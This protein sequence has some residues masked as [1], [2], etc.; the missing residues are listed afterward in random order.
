[1]YRNKKDVDKYV[2]NLISKL[3][4]K[5]F[6]TRAYSIARLYYEVGDY[7]SCKLYVEQYLTQKDN[8]AAAYKLLGQALQKLGQKEKALEQYKIALDIDPTQTSTILDICELLADDDVTIDPGRAKYWC[9]KAEATFPRHPVTFKMRERLI[10]ESNSDPEALVNLLTAELVARPKDALLHTR[11]LKHY[12][13]TNEIKKAVD[14]SCNIEFGAKTFIN[15]YTW[16]ETLVDLLKHDSHNQNDWVF[17]LLLLTVRE[18]ICVLSLTETPSGSSKSLVE[19]NELLHAYDQA[20]EIVTKAGA[21]PGYA[22]FHTGLLQHHRGQFAFIAATF[23]LKKAK[24]DQLSWRDATKF[25]APLMLIAWHTTP[26]DLKVNWLTHATEK[27]QQAARRWYTEGAYRCS[28]S[29]HYLLSNIQDQSQLLLD[30]ISQCCS[31]THWRDKLYEKIFTSRGHLTKIKSSHITSNWFNAPVLRL[32][33]K[34]EVETYD[35][36]AQKEYPN[37]LHHFVWILLNYKNYAHFK[38]TLFDMLTPTTSDCGPETLN[39]LDIH[40]F[41]YCAALTTRQ[42]KHTER[43]YV[44]ADKPTVLPA[45]IT[46]LLCPLSQMKW[47]DCAYKFSQNELGTEL[48]DIRATLSRGI[49]VVRCVDSYGLDPELLCTLGRIFSEKAK[50]TTVVNDK[51]NL[52]IRAGLYY[53]SAIPLLE[54]LKSKIVVKMPEKRLFDY[55]H[56]EL[57]TKDLISLIEES[58][59]FVAVN[60]LNDCDY[61]KVIEILSNLKSPQ[62]YYYLGLTYKKIA[63]DENNT[64]KD[65]NSLET[66]TKCVSLLTRARNYSYK[67]LDS[68]KNSGIN[69]DYP[70]YSDTQ[71]MIE[72]IETHLNKID[73][74]LSDTAVN[75]VGGKYSSDE[76]VSFIGSEYNSA[77]P[78]SHIFRNISSTPKQPNPNVTNYRTATDSHILESTRADQQFLER[79]ENEIKNLQKRDN[80]ISDFMEQS[81]T[82]FEENRKLSNQIISTIHTNIQNTTDQ[83]KLLKIS[84]DNVKDQ[85]DEC[86]NECKDVGDLKKQIAELKKEVNK[87][88]KASSEQTIDESDLYNLEDDYRT[89]ESTSFAA[90]LPFTPPQVLSSFNQR[91]VPPFPVP[92]NPYQ[93]Y[94][95]NLYNFYSQYPQFAQATQVPGAPPLFDP[96]RAPM[97]YPG[98]YTTPDQMYLDVSHLVPPNIPPP[99]VSSVSSVPTVPILPTIPTASTVP[100]A[101]VSVSTTAVSVITSKMVQPPESKEIPRSLPVNVVITSSD[102]LPTCTTTPAPILSVTIPSKHIKGTAHNYQIPMPSTNETK[103]MTPPIFS[104]PSGNKTMNTT[105]PFNNWNQSTVF[106]SQSSNAENTSTDTAS[107]STKGNDTLDNTVNVVDGVFTG[108]SPNT[109]L[110][111]SRTLSE[112]SNTSVENY[113]PCP[114]F[115]PIIPLPAEVKVTTGEEDEITIFSSRAKLFRFIDKQ[116]KE[117]GLGDMKLLKH[118]TTAK[119]RV[120]MRREQIHKICAN[121]I[122]TPEMEIKPM[123]NETKAY[124]WVAN[125]FADE[126][127]VL[128]K[129]CIRFKTADIAQQFYE[130]FEKARQ[131]SLLTV[132]N[133]SKHENK[134]KAESSKPLFTQFTTTVKNTPEQSQTS[135]TVI[136]GFTFSSTPTFKPV[137]TDIKS[138]TKSSELATSKTNVFSGLTFKTTTNSP[139][140]SLFSTSSNQVT[141]NVTKTESNKETIDK[142]NNSDTVEEFEPTVEFKPVVP[143]PAL[144]EQKTGEE[145]E[146]IMFEHRAKLLRFDTSIKE[147]KERGLGNIKLLVH[148][149]NIQ[150]VRL[151]MRREQ[152][153][154]VCCN[155]A[156]TKEMIFQKMP[157]MD[158][159]VTWGATDFS[160][161]ELVAETFCLRFKTA[162][163]CDSF[164]DA[165]KTAQSKMKDD[166]KAAKEEQNAAKQISQIGF[167]DK[168]KP[169]AGSWY[170]ETCYTNNLESF[171]K[172]ACCEQPKPSCTSMQNNAIAPTTST[173]GEAFKPK[174]GMWEC[175][176]C[177]IR[178][179]ANIELCSA[180]NSPKDPNAEKSGLKLTSDNAPKFNFG[181]PAQTNTT[182]KVESNIPVVTTP[183]SSGWGDKFKPKEGTWE[184]K[185][186]F[187][188]NE[189][190]NENCNACNNPK[191]PNS[192]KQEPKSLFGLGNSG[193]KFT[194]GIPS[195]TVTDQKSSIVPTTPVQTTSIFDGTGAHKFSFGISSNPQDKGLSI[196]SFGDKKPIGSSAFGS[197][198]TTQDNTEPVD[199]TTN[200]NEEIKIVTPVKPGLLPTPQKETTNTPL[201]KEG[202]TFDFVFKPKT[203]TK[204]KSPVKSPSNQEG[205]DS[206]GNE[207]A[208]EDE[209]HHIHFSPVIPMP[210]KVEVITG[211]E[212]EIELYGHRAKLFRFMS[213]EWKERGIGIVK[214][215]KHK[216]TGKVRVVMRREQVLK[217]CLNHVL[218]PDITYTPKDDKTWLFAANDFSEGELSLQQFCLRFKTNE[219][220][221]EFKEAIDKAR[222]GKLENKK[223]VDSNQKE[224]GDTDDVI[225]V[226]EIQAS[227]EEK[228]IAKELM[229]PEN[230]FT[231]KNKE[232]CLGCRGCRDDDSIQPVSANTVIKSSPFTSISTPIKTPS[233]TLQSPTQSLYGT[234]TNFD[235]SFDGSMFRTPLGAIGTN[236]KS[237]TLTSNNNSA[238]EIDNTNKENSFDKNS[239]FYSESADQKTLFTSPE[240]K[241]TNSVENQSQTVSKNSILAAPKLSNLNTSEDEKKTVETKS[242][243]GSTQAGKQNI[244]PKSV[245]AQSNPLF[246]NK[247]FSG[248]NSG[249]SMNQ[250]IFGITSDKKEEAKKPEVKSIFG[251]DE[252]K[253]VGFSKS[254]IFGISDLANTQNKSNNIFASSG[255]SIFSTNVQNQNLGTGKSIFGV[256]TNATPQWTSG[257][258]IEQKQSNIISSKGSG[259]KETD[260]TNT[261]NAATEQETLFKVDNHLS[262]AALSSSGPGFQKKSDFQWEGA[263]Q[264]LFGATQK[265][266]KDADTSKSE[267]GA[268]DEASAT[269]GADEE[270]D[271][272]YEPIV[273]L[274][275]KI[276]VTTGEED[277]EKLFGERCKLYRYDDKSREWKERGVGEMKILYHPQKKS[278]RLLLRREQVHKAV[279]NMLLFMDLELLPMKNS[280][281]AWTWAGRNYAET[282][283]GEQETLAVRFKSTELATAFQEKIIQCVRKL[284]AQAAQAIREEKE[285]KDNSFSGVAPLR[286]PKHLE[287][288]ARADNSVFTNAV[289]QT[290]SGTSATTEQTDGVKTE[291]KPNGEANK[292]SS[293]TEIFKQVHF[294]DPEEDN[295]DEDDDDDEEDYEHEYDHNEDYDGYYNEEEDESSSYYSCDGEVVVRQGD[296]ETACEHGHIQVLY[297][298]DVYSPKILITDSATG[299]ILADML[300]HTDTE[301]QMSGD[302]CVWSAKDYT[303]YEPVFKTVTVNFHDSE[304]AMLFYDSCETSKAATYTSTDPES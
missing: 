47:W 208:S 269:A 52:E 76:N 168:F 92:P 54:K 282:A 191:N 184:C 297:D 72:S 304:T 241:S 292:G 155:H 264:Q 205:E 139:F 233:F 79:I 110:N 132:A 231:Y 235:K 104:F 118:K 6:K 200:K 49:E 68:L 189:A 131:E 73:P 86:R 247:I 28:Q 194:F 121:H 303:S 202:G 107:N 59:L 181:I 281:R 18:R 93:L 255:K 114:D 177:L 290:Q 141:D 2:E 162:Q 276:V 166:S 148:K 35:I 105:S 253:Q 302:S 296:T 236:T 217:I 91:L 248:G 230:F 183:V 115:K 212:N 85:I 75:D 97:N 101:S 285:T 27:Q 152:I 116:W 158:K 232:P 81:K 295:Q 12:M 62:A 293:V 203:A 246:G 289:N 111:K 211:E 3:S 70:L 288:S 17:Q 146:N 167:G 29:G 8:N 171:D 156:I 228:K 250:S 176:Q 164:I 41:L 30:R 82:W 138:D 291:I 226:S 198:K 258:N 90:P 286:L 237:S 1:M 153:M 186:C 43:I 36:D 11:L 39:K 254:N 32:P 60:H 299:E 257:L 161:G 172:C 218:S 137:E 84:V 259:D 38:C 5:E 180:C 279:L 175:Q 126:T 77:R 225:F 135:K 273:P 23:L 283:A 207:Y 204:G 227:V 25:A 169:K 199:F 96:T 80:T 102:P 206:D 173:W 20:I 221:L 125:D 243:F 240:N 14:H 123:K 210:D 66:K 53:S 37:S 51:N 251:A 50:L 178:N 145:D 26:Q 106:Q 260:H 130:A 222:D 58:K 95:Q 44:V 140:S 64:S 45:I 7:A 13:Q 238:I 272:H 103:V 160:E 100:S 112:R 117:R 56:K 270:Y 24:K 129:F 61:V 214:I 244:E 40:A 42:Q 98:M 256:A 294:Q 119:V 33:R 46:D 278:Y 284:Q 15:N 185:E 190:N 109:S 263:G 267:S 122:I 271:P 89:N 179:E 74:D 252:Q 174:P 136:G 31:G 224:S 277:E 213:G 157:N 57:S 147:W 249:T 67:A 261:G 234:P 65:A 275:E 63:I 192:V 87:L 133:T 22:E 196:I 108:V 99:A 113:D 298:Q 48:T 88:K 245:F 280:D 265:S 163:T 242:V 120:L 197:L 10:T 16:Y 4:V 34:I 229:L 21:T 219:I 128:E 134:E 216:D 127:V 266:S 124:F 274:P 223:V 220:A 170:C 144:I 83:F 201:S 195:T 182:V 300:I 239:G 9:E 262:F 78:N 187:V 143:L 150:K 215:L 55:T 151:L 301:F 149:D 142:L 165:I 71:V 193:S 268:G 69:K 94:G 19:S 209:G 159:A 287:N 188:R 154:K